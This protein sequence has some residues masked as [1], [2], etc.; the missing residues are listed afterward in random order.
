MC[1]QKIINR[2]NIV[3]KQDLLS[4]RTWTQPVTLSFQPDEM[5]VKLITYCGFTDP[6]V[7]VTGCR[8]IW[9]S[10]IND[11]I[12][13]FFDGCIV[14]P[15][16]KFNAKHISNNSDWTFKILNDDGN[17][18]NSFNGILYVHIE[19]VEFEKSK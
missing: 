19:F 1:N 8:S 9:A 17:L 5:R 13:S 3:I 4:A 7:K 10:Q 2:K 11:H 15:N 6:T 14:A 16:M 18:D 12:G